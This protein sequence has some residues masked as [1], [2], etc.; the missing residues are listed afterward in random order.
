MPSAPGNAPN[1]QYEDRPRPRRRPRTILTAICAA[2]ALALAIAPATGAMETPWP[3]QQAIS[4]NGR[5]LA[6]APAPPAPV[7]V[8]IVDS[9]V[10][11]NP[12]TEGTVVFRTALGEGRP[13]DV[14]TDEHGTLMA[15]FAAAPANGWGMIGAAPT[16]VRIVSVRVAQPGETGEGLDYYPAGIRECLH[17]RQTYNIKVISL[18]LGSALPETSPEQTVDELV[19]IAHNYGID[20][21]AAAG[22]DAGPL[23]YP[24]ADPTVLSVGAIGSTHQLCGFS[25]I[26]A[27]LLAPGCELD[28]ADPLTGW[29]N[30]D[31]IQGTSPADA[32]V[33]G[34]LGALR[35]YR[36]ELTP[37]EAEQL[38]TSPAGGTLNVTATFQAAGLTSIIQAGTQ[39]EPPTTPSN[40]PATQDTSTTSTPS[41]PPAATGSPLT[42]RLPQPHARLRRHGKHLLL[43]LTSRPTGAE[44][45]IR[46]L[47][48]PHRRH[49]LKLP[50]EIT[51]SRTTIQMPAQGVLAVQARYIDPY[52][53]G[54]ASAWI[55]IPVPSS[56]A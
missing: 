52:D 4:D 36:P 18:S 39:A 16:A 5:F 51:S 15:M 48:R 24:A 56:T 10:N 54:R 37:E 8:C 49:E 43:S 26:G 11:L 13:D 50:Q 7:G 55:R 40:P 9:G 32:T 44:T 6:F 22:N 19:T 27:R 34:V 33:A 47:G 23:E 28:A 20:V 21:V 25:S 30:S 53:T 17:Y 1:P 2:L 41:A 29:P 42:T 3:T 35:A 46:L 31:Y 12:D 45:Q 38:L 14:S